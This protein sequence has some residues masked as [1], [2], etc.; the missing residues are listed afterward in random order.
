MPPVPRDENRRKAG[1]QKSMASK[2]AKPV[3]PAALPKASSYVVP[4]AAVPLGQAEKRLPGKAEWIAMETFTFAEPPSPTSRANAATAPPVGTA[5]RAPRDPANEVPRAI[6]SRFGSLVKNMVKLAADAS[7]QR[8]GDLLPCLPISD[9]VKQI[10]RRVNFFSDSGAARDAQFQEVWQ[11]IIKVLC[12]IFGPRLGRGV[13][14]SAITDI[15]GCI[16]DVELMHDAVPVPVEGVRQVTNAVYQYCDPPAAMAALCSVLRHQHT[17]SAHLNDARSVGMV[18][19]GIQRV[20]RRA[21]EIPQ[22]DCVPMLYEIQ[23]FCSGGDGHDTSLYESLVKR[24]VS[25]TDEPMTSLPVTGRGPMPSPLAAMR[26]AG[27]N[28]RDACG[29][30]FTNN[31]LRSLHTDAGRQRLVQI[32]MSDTVNG[33]TA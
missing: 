6:L 21:G 1:V 14:Q 27:C 17:E 9:V 5:T 7:E 19:D 20:S 4:P 31:A 26:V 10:A 22:R 25:L 33:M 23:K 2:P 3:P 28:I 16:Y 15:L 24:G 12:G 30:E 11:D 13:R 8:R 29:A 32:L 18:V